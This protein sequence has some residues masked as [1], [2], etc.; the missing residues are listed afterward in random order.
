M[1]IK[2]VYG[3]EPYSV[4]DPEMEVF[5]K[6][7]DYLDV[8]QRSRGGLFGAIKRFLMNNDI[9]DGEWK[10][11]SYTELVKLPYS[12]KCITVIVIA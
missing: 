6:A 11:M 7:M 4:N 12:G 2:D 5:L 9:I 3:Y 1:D 10:H 8:S